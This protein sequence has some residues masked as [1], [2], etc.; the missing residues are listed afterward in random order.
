M[1]V[2]SDASLLL[3][4]ADA[5][6]PAHAAS[7]AAALAASPGLRARLGSLRE[8][9]GDLP[10]APVFRIPPPGLG[11]SA[12]AGQPLVMGPPRLRVG[13]RF[14]VRLAARPIPDGDG[15]VVLRDLGAGW[16]IVTPSHPQ[17]AVPLSRL[18]VE[19]DGCH[20]VDLVARPPVG[21]QRWAVALVP[22]RSWPGPPPPVSA[23]Q[24]WAQLCRGLADGSV[25]VGVVEIELA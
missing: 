18:P 25:P 14:Q 3:Y 16:R 24:P 12:T 11:L 22:L 5:L 20:R 23:V 19:T 10:E 6:D 17:D 7:V 2:I 21:R 4:A 13:D 1:P 15:V 8:H 9:L